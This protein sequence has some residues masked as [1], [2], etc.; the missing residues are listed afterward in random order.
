MNQIMKLTTLFFLLPMLAAAQTFTLAKEQPQATVWY[1]ET[2]TVPVSCENYY[3]GT[4]HIP[5]FGPCEVVYWLL[6]FQDEAY[7]YEQLVS[8]WDGTRWVKDLPCLYKYGGRLRPIIDWVRLPLPKAI[9][10]ELRA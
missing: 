9:K 6:P 10:P 7:E 8:R 2:Q 1:A 4:Y 5:P 3:I